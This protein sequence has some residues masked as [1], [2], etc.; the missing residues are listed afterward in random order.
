M[1]QFANEPKRKRIADPLMR[2]ITRKIRA[3]L[4]DATAII[5]FGSRVA[6]VAD[7]FSDYDALV[8]LPEG[9]EENA[10]ARVKQEMQAAFPNAKLDLVFGSER[11]LRANLSR[12]EHLR[13]WLENGVLTYGSLARINRYPLLY[14]DVLATKLDLIEARFLLAQGWSRTLYYEAQQYLR[15]LKQLML[16]EFALQN[17]YRNEALWD[18]MRAQVHPDL[19]MILRDVSQRRRIRRPMV[20]RMERLVSRKVRTLRRD[21]KASHLPELLNSRR[22]PQ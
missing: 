10:R 17:D 16:I 18:A 4:P 14:K 20:R 5:F 9:L 1:N 6:G 13:F 22:K 12:E 8:L 7:A 2:T 11:W 21:L 19:L 15:L 3:R